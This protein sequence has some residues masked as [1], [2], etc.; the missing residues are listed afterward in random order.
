MVGIRAAVRAGLGVM[1]RSIAMLGPD[2]R[3]RG[4][5]EKLPQLPDVSF[6]LYLGPRNANPLARQI[7]DS[8]EQRGR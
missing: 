1:A 4:N 5:A 6:R 7:F 2:L 3:V 8:T